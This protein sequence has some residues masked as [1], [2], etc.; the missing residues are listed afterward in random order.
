MVKVSIIVPIYNV[1]QYLKECLDSLICQSLKDI[2]VI[3]VND[4]STDRCTEILNAYA[5][6]DSRFLVINQPNG[7]YGKAMNQGLRAATGEYVGIA[8]PDDYV[9]QH[10][11]GDLYDIAS[12]N[13]LDFVKAD[14]YRFTTDQT[15]KEQLIYEAL[16][17]EHKHYNEIFDPSNSPWAIRFTLNTWSGIY[18]RSFL[19]EHQILHN[20]TP[21]AAFQDNGFFWQTFIYG[22]RAMIVDKPYYHNRRDNPNS[23][24]KSKEKVYCMNIEYDYIQDILKRDP[25]IWYRFRSMYWW[26]KF[27]NYEFTLG[28]IDPKYRDEFLNRMGMEYKRALQLNELDPADFNHT[29]WKRIQKIVKNGTLSYKQYK[30]V[31]LWQRM[32]WDKLPEKLKNRVR[33]LLGRV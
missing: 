28:R 33:K 1:E 22:K 23:S 13:D 10:M 19:Q 7:G 9:D 29:Q 32:I 26:K 4:G 16:D 20:E 2:E 11:Y 21:G 31:P 25:E 8:E 17:R 6:K 3:C 14:F 12:K 30:E 27:H 5:Q 15:G 18:R 24:V